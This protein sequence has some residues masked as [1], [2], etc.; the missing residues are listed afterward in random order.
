MK[1]GPQNWVPNRE[2]E[3]GPGASKKNDRHSGLS[4]SFFGQDRA[5]V[6]AFLQWVHL[7]GSGTTKI[8]LYINMDETSLCFNYGRRRGLLVSKRALPPN[9]KYRKEQ[10]KSGD[11]KAYV[12]LLGFFT[13][14]TTI[15]AKLPQIFIGNTH[16]FTKK[17]LNKISSAVPK[18]F[19]L[20]RE[21]SSWNN[22]NLMRKALSLLVRHLKDYQESHEFVLVLDV[23]RCHVH[24]SIFSLASRLGV[25]LVFVP[26]KLTWLLQPADTHVFARFK[27][28]LRQLWHSLLVA[29]SSGTVS[30]ETW[31]IEVME[32]ARKLFSGVKWAPAF[33]AAG[34]L[35]S[36]YVSDRVMQQV[37]WDSLPVLPEEALSVQQLKYVFPQ[38]TRIVF[39]SSLFSWCLPKAAPKAKPS[40]ASSSSSSAPPVVPV[41]ELEGPIS[42]RTRLKRKTFV[43]V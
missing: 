13:H 38:R 7:A 14:D 42:S 11:L 27:F 26:A 5:K 37:G 30:N 2:P 15:Q 34:M 25:R 41:A 35:D 22:H 29:S 31:L 6:K 12:S 36:S 24:S 1:G 17:L 10:V 33:K 32:T 23:A 20:F 9:R 39:R 8:P 43:F 40:S 18:N 19:Y 3:L 21:Q 28:R 16:R 4:L